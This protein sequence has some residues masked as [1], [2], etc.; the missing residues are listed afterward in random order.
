MSGCSLVFPL[1]K[2]GEQNDRHFHENLH[3]T[4][5]FHQAFL[6]HTNWWNALG[7]RVQL[8][9]CTVQISII[10]WPSLRQT[11]VWT[12]PPQSYANMYTVHHV[13]RMFVH[14]LLHGQNVRKLIQLSFVAPSVR[15]NSECW[16]MLLNPMN[17][18]C[19]GESLSSDHLTDITKI[20]NFPGHVQAW[21]R[22]CSPLSTSVFYSF[23]L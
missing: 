17:L 12:C 3:C 22:L 13:Q 10:L 9:Q 21:Q 18:H 8:T 15:I 1:A 11:H 4:L 6:L 5:T 14:L 7:G 23:S 16:Q 20:H 19:Q 2:R